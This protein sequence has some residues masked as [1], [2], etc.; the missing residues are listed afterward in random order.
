[1]ARG[2]GRGEDAINRKEIINIGISRGRC[3]KSKNVQIK[4][5]ENSIGIHLQI[6]FSELF[7]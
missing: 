4:S 6:E 7:I 3:N 1:M 2:G 5:S